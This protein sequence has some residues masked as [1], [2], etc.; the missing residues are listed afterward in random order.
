MLR[1]RK[2][3]KTL[4]TDSNLVS[5]LFSQQQ[6]MSVF[7]SRG[8]KIPTWMIISP[9]M[10]GYCQHYRSRQLNRREEGGNNDET[11]AISPRFP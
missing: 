4:W 9:L 6:D 1:R 11:C 3:S 10:F 5:A 7:S 8:I 2:T